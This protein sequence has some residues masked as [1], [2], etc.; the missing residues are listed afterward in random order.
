MIWR[1]GS[2]SFS[3]IG[4][5]SGRFLST[6]SR[7]VITSS[8]ACRNS[9]W[10]GSLALTLSKIACATVLVRVL[11][12]GRGLSHIDFSLE[13]SSLTAQILEFFKQCSKLGGERVSAEYS[14]LGRG[15][16][17][18]MASRLAEHRQC[19]LQLSIV[20]HTRA[21]IDRSRSPRTVSCRR[22][23]QIRWV[24]TISPS[25]LSNPAPE[26]C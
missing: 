26:T 25:P 24:V 2:Q 3:R 19:K 23:G 5:S 20:T 1:S 14:P 9:F 15:M 17:P 8:T 22:A 10:S 4:M 12:S 21:A 16:C 6:G 11:H 18:S 13:R 7:V